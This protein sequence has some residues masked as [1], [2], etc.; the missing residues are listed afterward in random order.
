MH[1][2]D[3]LFHLQQRAVGQAECRADVLNFPRALEIAQVVVLVRNIDQLDALEP[4][5]DQAIGVIREIA[6][7]DDADALEM[8]AAPRQLMEQIFKGDDRGVRIFLFRTMKGLKQRT[9]LM[10]LHIFANG[11]HSGPPSSS[12][13]LSA[14]TRAAPFFK[15]SAPAGQIPAVCNVDLIKVDHRCVQVVFL[16]NLFLTFARRLFVSCM[17]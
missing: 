11:S 10:A 13:S 16:Q 8:D 2:D 3:L 14:R 1:R 12:G 9:S 17:L 7:A 15:L 4:L 5:L 6:R